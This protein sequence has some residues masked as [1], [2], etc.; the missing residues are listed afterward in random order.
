MAELVGHGEPEDGGRDSSYWNKP[1]KPAPG[2]FLGAKMT[3]YAG[4]QER[5]HR[6]AL[7]RA[8]QALMHFGRKLSCMNLIPDAS[9]E[10]VRHSDAVDCVLQAINSWRVVHALCPG[11][12]ARRMPYDCAI[13]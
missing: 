12:A 8:S 7:D 4:F 1:R 13:S 3:P 10:T 11:S 9:R 2:R 5:R 6:H